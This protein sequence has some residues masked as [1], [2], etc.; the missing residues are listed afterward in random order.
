MTHPCADHACD[1]CHM[2]DVLGICCST[3]RT[4][5]HQQQADPPDDD[6][7]EAFGRDAHVGHDLL[8]AAAMDQMRDVLGTSGTSSGGSSLLQALARDEARQAALA[9]PSAPALPAATSPELSPMH[10]ITPTTSTTTSHEETTHV[11]R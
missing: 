9:S 11:H 6:L 2:C 5:A 7:V 8:R 4:A 10:A 1:H 3:G